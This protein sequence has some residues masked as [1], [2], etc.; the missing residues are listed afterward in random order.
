MEI[1]IKEINERLERSEKTPIESEEKWY[2]TNRFF[3]WLFDTVPYGWRVYYR[4]GELRRWCISTYQRT[5]YGVSDAECWS[6][7]STLTKFILPRLKHFKKINVNSHPANITSE[8]WNEILDEIIWT[9]EYMNDFGID[10]YYINLKD[11]HIKLQEHTPRYQCFDYGQLTNSSYVESMLKITLDSRQQ[12]F[13]NDYWKNQLQH[14]LTWPSEAMSISDTIL[15]YG[16][17]DEIT[18]WNIA[19]VLYTF[20][21]INNLQESQRM[22]SI[23]TVKNT[24]W[25]EIIE[26]Q[27]KYY[28]F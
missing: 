8:Q 16:L 22:W 4:W 20:E 23:D 5:R 10:Y 15:W 3:D 12:K 18:D 13:F 9:F 28:N 26:L 25:A 11:W 7:E 14:N 19:L 6:L 1:P 2:R 21:T 24:S 17:T 27:H